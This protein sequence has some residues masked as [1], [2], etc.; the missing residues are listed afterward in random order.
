MRR[1]QRPPLV[2]WHSAAR[3]GQKYVPS[4]AP[5]ERALSA[6]GNAAVFEVFDPQQLLKTHVV[7]LTA[8][9]HQGWRIK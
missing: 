2:I 3:G 4:R 1:Q 6:A 9:G 7:A 8:P 5:S